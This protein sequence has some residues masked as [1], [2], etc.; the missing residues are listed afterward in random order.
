[1]SKLPDK[2]Q[3][4]DWITDNPARTAKRDI[5]WAFGIKGAARID[6]KRMLKELEAE[7]A[8]LRAMLEAR[9]QV[10][11]Q[12]R[13]AEIMSVSANPFRHFMVV[14]AEFDAG[15]V[16][17]CLYVAQIEKAESGAPSPSSSLVG[18]G[19]PSMSTSEE[20]RL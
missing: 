17:H 8:R 7:N 2:Q 18:I 9:S 3:I 1:M 13:V 19:R 4:L 20:S 5:A 10:R 11:A 14:D 12:V 6:L 16:C 15:G